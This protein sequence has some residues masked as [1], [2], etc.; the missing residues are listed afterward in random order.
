MTEIR[1]GGVVDVP[2]PGMDAFGAV[3]VDVGPPVMGPP[4][5]RGPRGERGDPGG[6]TTVVYA[7]GAGGRTPDELPEGGLI[8][9]GWDGPRAPAAD[10]QLGVGESAEYTLDGYLWLYVGPSA[11]PGGWIETGQ[12]RGPPGDSGPPGDRGPVGPAGDRGLAGPT[13][14]P[15]PRGDPGDPGP[16]GARGADGAPGT[17]GA[18]GPKGDRGDRGDPGPEGPQGERGEQGDPGSDGSDGSDGAPGA[19]SFIVMDLYQRTASE[20]ASIPSGLIPA[21]FDGSG[22]P[23]ADYQMNPGEAVLANKSSA[24]ADP[25]LGQAIVFIGTTT[26]YPL[27]WIAMPVTGP[28][29]DQGDQG[30]QGPRGDQGTQGP[31]GPPGNLWHWSPIDPPLA[32]IGVAGDMVLVLSHGNPDYPGNGNVY[33]VMIDGGYVLDGNIRGPV[34]PQGPPGEVRWAD[35]IPI[36][37]RLDA[38]TARVD[39]LEAI[40]LQTLSSDR[41]VDDE[42]DVIVS[43]V[44]LQPGEYQ[45]SAHLTFELN[46]IP[47]NGG[48]GAAAPHLLIAWIEGIG[49][50]VVTGPAAGQLTVHQALPY[51]SVDIGPLRVVVPAGPAANIVLYVR[52]VPIGPPRGHVLLKASTSPLGETTAK[53]LATGLV[54][55]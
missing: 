11:V 38:L 49:T 14:S 10:I 37:D 7:F 19:P 27:P 2:L 23:P 5:L 34:G 8:P 54:A 50:A 32:G 40:T 45:G 52:S 17:P 55:R 26:G 20:V 12:L 28:K 15:G 31:T 51:G 48:D 18:T 35:I 13:G 1:D 16:Q 47:A 44:V 29:G 42:A 4:G 33:R 41:A 43:T 30:D 3:A 22:R 6:T 25:Y 21:G 53:P 36:V 39:R 24:P 46:L 9:A